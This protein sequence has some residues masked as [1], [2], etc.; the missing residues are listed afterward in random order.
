M[1]G[2]CAPLF[3]HHSFVTEYDDKKPV[4]LTGVVTK[5][6]WANPHVRFFLDVTNPDQTVAT[7]ELTLPSTLQLLR[8][9]WTKDLL[10]VGATTTVD[11]FRARDGSQLANVWLVTL[12]DGRKV[13]AGTPVDQ[14]PSP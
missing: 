4:V 12:S 6:E 14:P 1:L 7:W 13:P 5:I 2:M 11:A 8:R 9:G 10:A 3:A